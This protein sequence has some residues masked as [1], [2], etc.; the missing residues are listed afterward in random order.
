MLLQTI[1]AN[2]IAFALALLIGLLVAWWLFGRG[3]RG[4]GGR[5]H[6]PDVLDEGGAPAQRNHA[7]IDAPAAVAAASFANTGPA[8]MGGMGEIVGAAAA[9]EMAD[10]VPR[11]PVAFAEDAD[12]L[13]RIKGVGPK[14]VSLLHGL[15]VARYA[16]IAAWTDADID[17][18]DGQLGAF[19]GRIRR[20]DWV[21][22]AKLL[23]A[24]DAAGFEAR[25]GKL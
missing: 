25:F 14:L 1:E 7:L 3:S 10:V 15:G 18:I 6:R 2:W 8:I 17:R 5:S 4:S 19:A 23:V 16:Q 13:R 20:D 11:E 21:E 12:D 24:G 22:Q 9:S